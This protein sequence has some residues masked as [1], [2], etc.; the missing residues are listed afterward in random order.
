MPPEGTSDCEL[1]KMDLAAARVL[2]RP[3]ASVLGFELIV[4]ALKSFLFAQ[5]MGLY[6]NRHNERSYLRSSTKLW[7]ATYVL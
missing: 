5:M 7:Y 6:A 2:E 4:V 3:P 1:A